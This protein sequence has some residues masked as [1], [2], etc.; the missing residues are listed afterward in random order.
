MPRVRDLKK[1]QLY[2]PDKNYNADKFTPLMKKSVNM[3][4]IA[5]QWNA[6]IRVL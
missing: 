5:E 6:L 4:L 1:Q 2:K 3:K